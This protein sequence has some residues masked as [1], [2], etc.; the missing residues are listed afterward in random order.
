MFSVIFGV[1]GIF[2]FPL[3]P[4]SAKL[5]VFY[6]SV[7]LLYVLLGIIFVRL[8]IF[9]VLRILGFE[10]WIFP[11]LFQD[12]SVIESFKPF[13]SFH[14]CKDNWNGLGIR[15]VGLLILALFIYKLAEEP[16]AL[17]EFKDIGTQ[18]FD[19]IIEW[20]TLRLEGK[21]VRILF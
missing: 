13:C 18:S 19:D 3:W 14:R 9:I 4:M 12:V 10:F 7:V 8:L 15:L 1:F 2:L 16:T 5:V 21:T 6:I 11:N 20:G 17:H